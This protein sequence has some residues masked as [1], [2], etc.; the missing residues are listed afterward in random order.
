M[1]IEHCLKRKSDAKNILDLG[2]G[3]GKYAKAFVN[4][5]LKPVLYDLPG[6]IDCVKTQ[7]GL[8]MS[9]T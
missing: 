6:T 7:F 3:P 5:G 8:G 2:G 9:G 4:R 1:A